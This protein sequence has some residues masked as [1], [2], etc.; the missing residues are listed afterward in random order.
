MLAIA[1]GQLILLRL[2]RRHREQ[3]RSHKGFV[4]NQMVCVYNRS[5]VGASLLAKGVAR[6]AA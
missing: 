2:I 5:N 6:F 4:V 3:A 1:P